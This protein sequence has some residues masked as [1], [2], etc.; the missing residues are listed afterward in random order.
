MTRWRDTTNNTARTLAGQ[1]G[2][3]L[4]ELV[5]VIVLTAIIAGIVAVFITRPIESYVGLS[6]RATLVDAADSALHRMGRDIHRALPNSVRVDG[7]GRVIETLDTVDGARYRDDPPGGPCDTLDFSQP[8]ADFD[9]LGNFLNTA[10]G[11]LPPNDRLAIY[12]TGAVDASGNPV[13]GANA[14][15]GPS[16]GPTPPA[17]SNVITPAGTTITLSMPSACPGSQPNEA[18]VHLSPAFQFSFQSPAQRLFIVDTPVTYL[19]DPTA[20]TV[21]RYWGYPI[22]A[23]QLT[24]DT[25]LKGA[26]AQSAL[27]TNH[28]TGC[29]FTYQPGT[30]QRAGLVTLQLTLTGKGGTITLLHQVHVDNSP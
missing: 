20:Q 15:A 22:S 11:T 9:L 3:T 12:N 18:H 23:T 4:I 16:P 13:P 14:Y 2:F 1:A 8:D 25:A 27:L 19:C 7:T 17:G 5:V 21:T 10:P 24:S 28:V 30:S 29:Q 26:G 6:Q